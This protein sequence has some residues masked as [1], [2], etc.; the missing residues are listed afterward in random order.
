MLRLVGM[1][2]YGMGYSAASISTVFDLTC[3]DGK[4][5]T[6]LQSF[7]MRVQEH[8]RAQLCIG[9]VNGQVSPPSE[10]GW[11]LHCTN[12]IERCPTYD[13]CLNN[14]SAETRVWK[15]LKELRDC[16]EEC[17]RFMVS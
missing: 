10:L 4:A 1:E 3:V 17:N 14:V 7:Q 11:T 15:R 16:G 13:G 8:T 2:N 12:T 6:L 9:L 5:A